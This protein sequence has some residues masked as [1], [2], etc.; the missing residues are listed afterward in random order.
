MSKAEKRRANKWWEF[1]KFV[2]VGGVSFLLHNALYLL[3]LRLSVDATVAYSMGYAAWM[4]S[5]FL[6]S[7]Y[8][9]FH[10]RPTWR[11]AF[12]FM[13]SS[14]AYYLIQLLG[15][16]L[17]RWLEVPDTIL[18]PL[19]YTVAFPLNFLMVRYVLKRK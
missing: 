11:R 19:V 5:N 4:V 6:L 15:F 13:L 2:V 8:I 9:T 7:N 12:G 16:A 10:T 1:A 3:L 18:T 17:C 14:A